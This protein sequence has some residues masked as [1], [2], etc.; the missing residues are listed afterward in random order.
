[1]AHIL[2]SEDPYITLNN[3]QKAYDNKKAK[4]IDFISHVLGLQKLQTQSETIAEAF[5]RFIQ[6]HSDF[7]SQQISFLQVLK[8]FAI[9]RGKATRENLVSPPFTHIHPEGI[10]GIFKP[11]QITEILSFME[12]I[13][14]RP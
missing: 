8:S 12:K 5:A 7:N 10:R 2:Q 14:D 9:E 3:L 13:N 1:M 6:N 11:A 4:F